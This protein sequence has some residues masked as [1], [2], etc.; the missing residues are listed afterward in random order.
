[1][2]VGG[3]T[4]L[5]VYMCTF[6]L[7]VCLS[8]CVLLIC[9]CV[10]VCVCVCTCGPHH[11]SENEAAAEECERQA[12]GHLDGQG[13]GADATVCRAVQTRL[14]QLTHVV[15][16]HCNAYKPFNTHISFTVK[17]THIVSTHCNTLNTVKHKHIVRR[18]TLS[19]H[20][21]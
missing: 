17:H 4:C 11:Y 8:T 1:M 15:P 20:T 5:F 14:F 2:S 18:Q 10:C 6:N 21:L 16:T 19:P 3:R 7:C 12:D 9:V 13:H